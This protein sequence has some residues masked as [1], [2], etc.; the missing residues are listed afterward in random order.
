MRNEQPA[1]TAEQRAQ[2][3]AWLHA[4][5]FGDQ[6]ENDTDTVREARAISG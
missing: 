3:E 4:H 2:M 6:K 5:P 1:L